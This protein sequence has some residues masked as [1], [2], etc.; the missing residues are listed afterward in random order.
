MI[1]GEALGRLFEGLTLEYNIDGN[2][3]EKEVKYHY[4]DH[5]ELV[6]WIADKKGSKYPL[7][8]YV[9]APYNE[10]ANDVKNVTS[11]LIIFQQTQIDWFNTK[12]TI[13]SYDAIIEPTW[14]AVKKLMETNRYIDILGNSENRYEI[15]D[16]PSYGVTT[17]DVRLS[18]NSFTTSTKKGTESVTLDV[19]DGRIIKMNFRIQTK[20]CN[21]CNNGC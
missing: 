4:G 12:R 5:K 2:V 1:I 15:K 6:K 8:W 13:K 9:I 16:E 3:I 19:V 18:Q 10:E 11:Q 7:V 17:D 20:Q 14:K 21:T